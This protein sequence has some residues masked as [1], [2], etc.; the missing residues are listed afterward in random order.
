V[1]QQT[2]AAQTGFEKYGRKSKRERFLEEMER[3][4]PWAEV[5]ALIEP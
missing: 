5:K 2:L 4:V 1:R 3:I